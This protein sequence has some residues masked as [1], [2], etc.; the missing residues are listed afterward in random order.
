MAHAHTHDHHGHDHGH[1]DHGH[2]HSHAPADFGRA[3]AVATILNLALVAVQVVYGLI[4][5]SVALL[6]DAGHNFGDAVGL[7]LAWGAHLLVRVRVSDRFTYGFRSASI[8][9]A[10]I[11]AVLLLV[12]TGAIALEAFR[13]LAEPE[14]VAGATVM[15]VAGA[16]IVINGFSAWLLMAGNKGDLN[17]RGAFLHLVAD[18]LVSVAVVA[19]GGII[20]LTGWDWVDPAASLIIAVVIVWGTWNLLRESF[21]LSMN[22]VPKGI[23]L[24]E[25]RRHL[26]SLPHV[27]AVHD[28]HVWAMSTTENAL[29]AHLVMDNGHPGDKFLAELSHE[30]DDRFRIQHATVQIEIGDG[31][32]C[33]LAPADT[34]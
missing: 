34:V 14:P 33:V 5:D 21:Q 31:N 26:Q 11:N 15:I 20:I 30:L 17:V 25:V 23:V 3:F 8:L 12:A 32:V 2:G 7:I 1:G 19:A 9:S 28:L 24:G 27:T 22:A 18:A 16:G 29:T 6:A 4:A 13:R 10:L